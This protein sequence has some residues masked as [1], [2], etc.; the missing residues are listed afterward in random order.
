MRH[1]LAVAVAT[2]LVCVPVTAQEQD[3]LFLL[4]FEQDTE[5]V[6][7][8]DSEATVST[9]DDPEVVYNGNRSLQVQYMQEAVAPGGG[10]RGF[11]GA[12]I[13]PLPD[14]LEELGGVSFAVAS[15][16]ST[17]IVVALTEGAEGPRYNCM[18]WCAAGSWHEYSLALHEFN[19][20]LDG[21]LDPNGELDPEEV[22]V[23]T[24]LDAGGFLRLLGESTSLFHVDPPGEQTLW[25]DD[26]KLLSEGP[27]VIPEAGGPVTIATYA[28]PLRGFVC[29]GGQDVTVESEEFEDGEYALRMDYSTPPG[30]LFAAIHLARPGALAGM[31]AIRFHART[32]RPVTLIVS[33]EEKRGPGDENKSSYYATVPLEP[34]EDW[35]MV[36]IP[37][38][39]FTLG[40]DAFDTN[41]HLDMDV[42]N[43]VMIGDATA[44]FEDTE[45]INSL[46]LRG[47][48]AV[49]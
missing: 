46:W 16:L 10:G 35:E 20:D 39:I 38:S 12:L 29:V 17:P 18:L 26:F 27:E 37:I 5:G 28:P 15:A 13:V 22:N 6:L 45:V 48:V 23:V 41:D 19:A 7:S 36:T 44:A 4:D 47:L 1:I 11:P 42:V 31:G 9:M 24:I 25:L 33:L 8:V 3:V 2:V 43:T 30:T 32:N 40:D 21:P 49:E 14:P 34:S